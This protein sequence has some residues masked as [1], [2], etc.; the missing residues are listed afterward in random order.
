MKAFCVTFQFISLIWYGVNWNNR[1]DEETI[2]EYAEADS[3]V[4]A[5]CGQL[6][7][8]GE[9]LHTLIPKINDGIRYKTNW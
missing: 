6:Q 3:Y 8:D 7:R 9:F 1:L 4:L 2:L 5:R